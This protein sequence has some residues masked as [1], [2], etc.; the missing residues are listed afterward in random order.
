MPPSYK[1]QDIA[2]PPR[3][4]SLPT[5][6]PGSESVISQAHGQPFSHPYARAAWTPE[7][8]YRYE[9][10]PQQHQQ[11][12]RRDHVPAAVEGWEE[13]TEEGREVEDKWTGNEGQNYY[14]NESAAPARS[15]SSQQQPPETPLQYP[16]SPATPMPVP[17]PPARTVNT[18]TA[19]TTTPL[20][21][22]R[23]KPTPPTPT[24]TS[25]VSFDPSVP[26]ALAPASSSYP[27]TNPPDSSV[28]ASASNPAS[29][30]TS[31]SQS[32]STSMLPF[33]YRP[34]LNR[35]RSDSAPSSTSTTRASRRRPLMLN[36]YSSLSRLSVLYSPSRNDASAS[37][38]PTPPLQS[39]SVERRMGELDLDLVD[40]DDAWLYESGYSGDLSP[41]G[42]KWSPTSRRA[43][44]V[45]QLTGDDDAQAFHNAKLAQARLPWYLQ[46][47]YSAD[48]I[49]LEYDGSVRAGTLAAL[50]ERL[51]VDPL[52]KSTSTQAFSPA[53][54]CS[55]PISTL[56]Y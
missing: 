13:H 21:P 49:K 19:T 35:S 20:P 24:P 44:K 18:T 42:S 54:C 23:D 11:H 47:S 45:R 37:D 3:S 7:S 2:P 16:P 51:T 48:E 9:S 32:A 34:T 41:G 29:T 8:D 55:S 10:T 56:C 52:S 50:V 17:T 6:H 22:N 43:D 38:V 40:D 1:G 5:L 28:S 39:S 46:P 27:T 12:H 26:A 25:S 15:L 4:Y 53:S 31:P 36:D 33:Q 30:F 14:P